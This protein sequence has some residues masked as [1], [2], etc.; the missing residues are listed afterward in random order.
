MRNTFIIAKACLSE[1]IYE[2]VFYLL[3]GFVLSMMGIGFL[4]GQMTY[5]EHA[6]L[7]LDFGLAAMEI[8]TVLFS[9]FMSIS[10]LQRE[11]S[12]G[13]IALVLAKPVSRTTFLI[14]KF[15]GQIAIQAMLLIGEGLVLYGCTNLFAESVPFAPIA[16]GTFLIFLVTTII[17]AICYLLAIQMNAVLTSVT[18]GGFYLLGSLSPLIQESLRT[19]ASKGIWK[20]LRSLVPQ[21]HQLNIKL[22]VSHGAMWSA[23]EMGWATL[24]G[25]SCIVMF[26]ALASVC[27]EHRDI[28]T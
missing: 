17:V 22:F 23:T 13:S 11:F 20:A 14:G 9:I 24:Y 10:L 12:T 7:T 4:L 6:K 2:K 16:Q 15:L 25:V 3:T 1:L 27:F 19:P 28:Q 18:A 26:L 5:A 21:F 8:S